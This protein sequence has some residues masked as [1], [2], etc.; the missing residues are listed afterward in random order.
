MIVLISADMKMIVENNVNETK[1]ELGDVDDVRR[2]F[3]VNLR[4]H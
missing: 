3:V 2:Y 4:G 1:V